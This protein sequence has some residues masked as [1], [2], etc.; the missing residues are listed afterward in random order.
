M[1][2]ELVLKMQS[3][4]KVVSSVVDRDQKRILVVSIDHAGEL[5]VK[6]DNIS[7]ANLVEDEDS[8]QVIKRLL[9]D[10][11]SDSETSYNFDG[12][13]LAYAES[14]NLELPKMIAKIG[15]KRWKG[16]VV[17]KTLSQYM[18]LLGFGLNSSLAY[19]K[20]EDKPAWWPKRPKWKNFRSPSRIA[21]EECTM[22]IRKLLFHYQVDPDVHYQGYPEEEEDSSGEEELPVYAQDDQ[23]DLEE[24][25]GRYQADV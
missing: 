9:T 10:V 23:M 11:P 15:G 21:K 5:V 6:G 19:G 20:K 2:L 18:S 12:H 1:C 4:K 3:L 22:L 7:F 24:E 14:N 17:A 25:Y 8:Q 16:A 13:Q